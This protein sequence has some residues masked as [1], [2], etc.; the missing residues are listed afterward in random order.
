MR[1]DRHRSAVRKKRDLDCS[2]ARCLLGVG[3]NVR[4]RSAKGV[5]LYIET[6]S[7]GEPESPTSARFA[8]S[9]V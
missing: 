8:V 5:L 6:R 3:N 4:E 1:C 2:L 9:A 7:A